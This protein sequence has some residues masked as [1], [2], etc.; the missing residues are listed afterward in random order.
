MAFEQ[1][2][3]RTADGKE[4]GPIPIGT[5]WEW[6]QQG[7]VPADAT[8]VDAVTFEKRPVGTV[9]AG[10]TMPPPQQYGGYPPAGVPTA[11]SATDHLIPAKNPKALMAYYLGVFGLIPCLI[12]I[13]I[14]ALIFGIIGVR[15]ANTLGVGKTHAIVGIVL[16][17]LETLAILIGLIAL[18]VGALHLG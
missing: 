5:L 10:M 4:Y 8:L 2:I 7:R 1:V 13:G 12:F 6:Q 11:P 3:M 9:L 18:I 16:G 14:V 17:S 15:D